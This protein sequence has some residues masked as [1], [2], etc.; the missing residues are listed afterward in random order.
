[1]ALSPEALEKR[2]K[3]FQDFEYYAKNALHIRT[4]PDP[5]TGVAKVVPFILNKA[6]K[7][8]LAEV[9]SQLEERGFVRLVILK[10]RQMGSSTFVEAFLYWWVTQR[11]AQ[12]ALVV[13]HDGPAAASIFGMTKRFHDKCPEILKPHTR[14][15]SRKELVFDLLDSSYMVATAGG[16]GI[17]RGETI[18]AAHLS[19]A[20]WWPS[21]GAESNYSG[22]MD[23]IPNA[24]GT[25]VFEE[26]TANS[27]NQFYTHW[28]A[29]CKGDSLFRPIFLSWL[30][31]EEY[32]ATVPTGFERTP[33]EEELVARYGMTDGQ[34]VFRRHK[35]ADKGLALFQQEFPL[36]AEEA[37]LTSGH[38]VFNPE[39]VH[40][41]LRDCRE[42]LAKKTL[43]L[44]G[45]WTQNP[46]GELH[47]FLPHDPAGTY[48]IG[49]DASYGVRKDYAVAQVLDGY[50]RQAAVWRSNRVDAD[51]F[52]TVVAAMGR[53]FNNAQIICE[54]N[55][56]GNLT[57]RVIHKDEE[58]PWVYQETQYDK[59]TDTE[60]QHVGFLTTEKS[61]G[62][63][64]GELQAAL[65][66]GGLELYDSTTL[67]EMQSF[68]Q[69]ESGRLEAEK[70]HHDDHVMSLALVNHIH[71]GAWSPVETPDELY[72]SIE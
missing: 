38:P 27:F 12:K 31:S 60:T 10:G 4:K 7:L 66:E 46:V 14:Y 67:K 29:A 71:E 56:P 26:S 32:T 42:P 8:I 58:Y 25:L 34:L 30:L 22:L 41:M 16:D 48:Y 23:A 1:M 69:T 68:I 9:T 72:V 51:R 15:S 57:N 54:R 52:G 3:L 62:L 20:A 39:R 11:K 64:I 37:F 36:C 59:V 6:Q 55:A 13:A 53:F 5:K 49:A 35:I 61:K 18:T 65:R 45:T 43:E 19:E 70:G 40:E 28:E 21:H 47:C 63:V 44:D 17:S 50:K 24:R 2:K 33:N